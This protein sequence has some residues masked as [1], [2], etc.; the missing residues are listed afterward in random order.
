MNIF[1][2]NAHWHNRGDEA[3]LRAMIDGLLRKYPDAHIYLQLICKKI[4]QFP[5]PEKQLTLVKAFPLRE[6]LGELF[7]LVITKGKICVRK[8]SKAFFHF[9][10]MADL[11]IHAPGGPSIGDTYKNSEWN[12][13]IRLFF[14]VLYKKPLFFYASSM[15]PFHHRIRNILRR[16]ILNRADCICLR[17]ELSGNHLKNLKLDKLPI[18]TID[19]AF[20]NTIEKDTYEKLLQE[21]SELSCFTQKLPKIVGITMTDLQW[22]PRHK[23]NPMLKQRIEDTF[24]QIIS[25]LLQKG[26]GIIFFPQLFE[27]PAYNDFQYMSGIAREFTTEN[28]YVLPELYDTYFQQYL[29]SKMFA[30][31]G[32]RYHSNIFAAKMGVPFIS[33]SY[34]EKMRGFMDKIGLLDYCIDVNTLQYEQI[35]QKFE[36]I[37]NNY[38]AYKHLLQEK[39]CLLSNEAKKTAAYLDQMIEHYQLHKHGEQ[40]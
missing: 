23:N 32:M 26:Y 6:N 36:A 12:Y 18:I 3:A 24:R 9:L 4:Q 29:I 31:I 33:I 8:N 2:I 15:G 21:D 39:S 7:L 34:E 19:T 17:E 30:T 16:W 10:D 1:I 5:V 25:V 13:L 27:H 22:H 28:M 35:I 38:A 40:L 20:Q 11:V 37:E 14:V